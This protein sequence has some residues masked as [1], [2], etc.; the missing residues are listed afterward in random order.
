VR[1]VGA[2]AATSPEQWAAAE[3][4]RA[5]TDLAVAPLDPDARFRFGQWLLADGRGADAYP[6]LAAA[7]ALAAGR[8]D[9][10]L[11]LAEAA[12]Q[13]GRWEEAAAAAA[14]AAAADPKNLRP[15]HLRGRAAARL[16]RNQE[17][18]RAYSDA[19]ELLPQNIGLRLDRADV[20][21]AAGD[22]ANAEADTRRA[23]DLIARRPPEA[24]NSLAW[25]L[26]TGPPAERNPKRA[27]DL[28]ANLAARGPLDALMLNTH[29]VVQYRNGQYK[30]AV[31][32]LEKSLAAGAG[33]ADAFDLFFLAMCH[34]RLGDPVAAG[35]QYDAAVN[36]TER[37][38]G[39][40]GP[41]RAELAAFRRE[42]EAELATLRH[43]SGPR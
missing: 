39:L 33:R 38:Q 10:W 22:P 29:G 19:L 27:L 25:V 14:R 5:A 30:E 15:L 23:D 17:A 8:T 7:A 41:W 6:H 28:M 37:A 9:A 3:R 1:V 18:I 20:Y 43:P 32:T 11:P 31:I 36:W 26:V 24:I 34:H 21:R 4:A 40:S 42:A 16:G 2:A 35:R 12:A 13:A